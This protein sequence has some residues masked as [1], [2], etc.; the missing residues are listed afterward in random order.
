MA[1]AL[2]LAANTQFGNAMA[3][4]ATPINANTLAGISGYCDPGIQYQDGYGMLDRPA[5]IL[6]PRPPVV[7]VMNLTSGIDSQ[8]FYYTVYLTIW[9]WNGQ[10]WVQLPVKDAAGNWY[11]GGVSQIT[12]SESGY[13]PSN[14][15]TPQGGFWYNAA[16]GSAVG[17]TIPA[18]GYFYSA[19]N[20][21]WAISNQ[22][23]A[24]VFNTGAQQIPSL[25]RDDGSASQWCSY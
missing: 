3:L 20:Q 10:A 21:V 22:T 19:W 4:A 24:V 14:N 13:V 17:V 2:A 23:G 8:T 5:A 25:T 6:I 11:H 18:P 15:I 12:L 1:M 7:Q 9:S 16:T